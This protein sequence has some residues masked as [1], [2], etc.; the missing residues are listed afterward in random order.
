MPTVRQH[1]ISKAKVSSE[2]VWFQDPAL[3]KNNTPTEKLTKPNGSDSTKRYEEG[4]MVSISRVL[5]T[6]TTITL[7]SNLPELV[8]E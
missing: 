2:L 4:D 6:N 7:F 3:K 5:R 1:V 8:S